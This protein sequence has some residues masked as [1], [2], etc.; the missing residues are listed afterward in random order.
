M[1][2]YAYGPDGRETGP[3][4]PFRADWRH[5]AECRT[6]PPNLFSTAGDDDDEPPYPPP[7]AVAY[8]DR[9]PV[10]T[11]CLAGALALAPVDD[12]G[13][14]G[15]T[16]RY[17]RRQMRRGVPRRTCLGCGS[18][19]LVYEGGHELCLACGVSWFAG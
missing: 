12:W 7:A 10:R 16:S 3:L 14:R 18:T 17:Q 4:V 6:A 15:G 8:C 13:V 5:L 19:D 1:T 2:T 9:C 11:E